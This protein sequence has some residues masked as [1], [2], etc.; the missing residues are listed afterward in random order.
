MERKCRG[1]VCLESW[2]SDVDWSRFGKTWRPPTDV[3]ET[4]VDIVIKVELAGMAEREFVIR[5]E[6][7]NLVIAGTRRD[8]TLKLKYRQMEIFCGDFVTSVRIEDIVDKAG[9][10]ATYANGFLVVVLPKTRSPGG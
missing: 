2:G 7:P 1:Q 5:F 9:V 4:D 8:V 3:Y 10:S 6:G